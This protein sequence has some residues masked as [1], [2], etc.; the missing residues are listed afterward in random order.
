MTHSFKQG[1]EDFIECNCGS[2]FIDSNEDEFSTAKNKF[3]EHLED[4]EL[5][6]LA[7]E[8]MERIVK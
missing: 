7:Q 3:L 8:Y 5:G 6:E 4:L 2:K 1:G